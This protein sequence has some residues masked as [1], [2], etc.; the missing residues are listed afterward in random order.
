MLL[1]RA[2]KFL[3]EIRDIEKKKANEDIK[4]MLILYK[5]IDH[6]D[7]N[8][9]VPQRQFFPKN[10]KERTP[11]RMLEGFEYVYPI[12]RDACERHEF[13]A[14]FDAFWDDCKA[15]LGKC[16]YSPYDTL[17]MT[18]DDLFYRHS[19][20]HWRK[21]FSDQPEGLKD[22]YAYFKA[23]FGI[24]GNEEYCRIDTGREVTYDWRKM[25]DC[26]KSM[27]EEPP[28]PVSIELPSGPR[29]E[30]SKES[31][32]KLR[33]KREEMQVNIA[34]DKQCKDQVLEVMKQEN[35]KKGIFENGL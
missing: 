2:I 17:F 6:F 5:G 34:K 3:V 18:V 28:Q 33:A 4:K 9:L 21:E 13:K 35:E 27:G 20:N 26:N 8:L 30:W 7:E 29:S 1:D 15:Y 25:K 19:F 23:C 32:D 16:G 31:L 14:Q 11:I 10:K 12:L 22:M 24:K